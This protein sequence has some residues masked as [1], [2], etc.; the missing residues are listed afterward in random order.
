MTLETIESERGFNLNVWPDA[1]LI[2]NFNCEAAAKN[3]D[4][5]IN[6]NIGSKSIG[7][8]ES[9]ASYMFPVEEC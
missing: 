7:V 3:Q 5:D 8:S 4:S 2:R 9:E 6:A 1:F